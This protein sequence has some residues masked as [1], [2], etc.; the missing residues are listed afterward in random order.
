MSIAKPIRP[1]SRRRS[2]PDAGVSQSAF[3][4]M[5]IVII[6]VI[7]SAMVTLG[8]RVG[9]AVA[10]YFICVLVGEEDC[11]APDLTAVGNPDD[12]KPGGA[13][14]EFASLELPEGDCR[15]AANELDTIF[16]GGDWGTGDF[17]DLGRGIS[18][19]NRPAIRY[20]TGIGGSFSLVDCK[21]VFNSTEDYSTLD[22]VRT[23]I[24]WRGIANTLIA[25]AVG[26][27]SGAVAYVI[28]NAIPVLVPVCGYVAGFM[29]GFMWSITGA[30]LETGT[31]DGPAAV[32][33]LVAG[34]LSALPAGYK[35][36]DPLSK[37]LP[38]MMRALGRVAVDAWEASW[39]W[40]KE[41]TKSGVDSVVGWAGDAAAYFE[42]NPLRR[43]SPP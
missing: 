9:G 14:T 16:P 43:P 18:I 22:E 3:V 26:V 13:G 11:T 36:L 42:R 19:G 6:L 21:L 2:G 25:G 8:P 5:L 38:G 23:D 27:A 30:L 15:A 34:I 33:A 29:I 20:E 32:N 17:E 35:V 1:L 28:C 7:T 41:M 10:D 39:G 24:S 4:A 31:I 37:A 40:V 12:G